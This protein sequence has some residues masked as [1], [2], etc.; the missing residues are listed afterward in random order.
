MLARWLWPH[1]ATPSYLR[2]DEL[3]ALRSAVLASP[4]L[5]ETDLNEGFE[6]TSG[7]TLLFDRSQV[8]RVKAL[9]PELT[10]FLAKAMHLRANVFFLNPLVIHAGGSGVAPHADKTLVSY[11]AE[12][13]PPYPFAVSVLY[14]SLPRE[15]KGGDLVFHRLIGKLKRRPEENMLVEFPGW[16]LH[17]VTPL[18][19]TEG[20]PPRVSLVLE[21]Y[22][23][24]EE[25]RSGI[26]DWSLET[27]RPF[28]EFFDEASAEDDGEDEGPDEPPAE[29]SRT[30]DP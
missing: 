30:A 29:P 9:M 25:M 7:F 15:K 1:T 12:G 13:E 8:E 5:A 28:S 27:T 14:L 22:Q 24:S 23:V 4:Y 17:E 10:P 6:G 26:P 20:S 16:M 2:D 19:S 11:V 21:Q 18:S 3:A